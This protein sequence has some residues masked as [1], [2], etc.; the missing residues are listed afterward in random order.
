MLVYMLRWVFSLHVYVSIKNKVALVPIEKT[1]GSCLKKWIHPMYKQNN[2]IIKSNVTQYFWNQAF[3]LE[4]SYLTSS[5]SGYPFSPV[6]MSMII[7]PRLYM[8]DLN[9]ICLAPKNSGAKYPLHEYLYNII[10]QWEKDLY[11]FMD[12][13]KKELP[14]VIESLHSS[15]HFWSNSPALHFMEAPRQAEINNFRCHIF[16]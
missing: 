13:Q 10:D 6:S 4:Q 2:D 9:V 5:I 16:I 12:N 7:I 8:S 14:R 15:N 1:F 11:Y 3:I